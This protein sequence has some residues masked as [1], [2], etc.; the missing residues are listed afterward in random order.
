MTT[1]AQCCGNCRFF[2][3][4]DAAFESF[5]RFNIDQI[6][7]PLPQWTKYAVQG[8]DDAVGPDDGAGCEAWEANQ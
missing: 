2:S 5:C 8:G 3:P 6:A 1:N 4:K 7:R